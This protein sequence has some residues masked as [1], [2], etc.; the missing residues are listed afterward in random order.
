MRA[1]QVFG[2]RLLYGLPDSLQYRIKLA[3]RAVLK[4]FDWPSA[5]KELRIQEE[6]LLIGLTQPHA[7]PKRIALYN[8]QHSSP[9]EYGLAKALQLRGH[10]IHGILCDG[11]LPLCEMNLGP[12]IRPACG[13][14]FKFL[15]RNADAFGFTFNRLSNYLSSSDLGHA[16]TLVG[17]VADEDL[18]ALQV[19]GVPVGLF[20]HREIQRYYR[21]F[22]FK[23]EVD[24]SFRKWIVSAVLHTWLA[25]RWLDEVKPDI[26]GVCSGRTLP[27]ACV[28]EVA[29]QNDIH[30]VTW[31]GAA[32]RPDS[33]MF[34]HNE[35]ATEIPLDSLWLTYRDIPLSVTQLNELQTFMG[36]WSRSEI[37]PF[38]Y[39]PNPLKDPQAIAKQL[40]LRSNVPLVVAFTNTSWDIAVID[41]DH[42]FANMFEWI[43]ALVEF[44]LSHL[45]FDFVIRAHPA[46]KKVPTEM[47]SR[48]PVGEEIRK[49]FR[50][51]PNLKIV[52]GDDPISSY[53][54]SEMAQVNMFYASRLGL[55]IAL[56][57]KRPWIAGAVTY[58]NK[59]FTLDIASKQHLYSLLEQDL[60]NEVLDKPEIQLAER[61]AYLWFFRY[62]VRLPI[63][64]PANKQ[65]ELRSFA[66]LAPGNRVIDSLC[67]SFVT[68]K[69]FVASSL[70]TLAEAERASV[71]VARI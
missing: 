42:G 19:D 56:R 53:T 46:E 63:L 24:P 5:T 18:E 31:D 15:N 65:F 47:Q 4:D 61:F 27:T 57:G 48:T 64:H 9:V 3:K 26:V 10:D 62:E 23:P 67:E 30:V 38:P 25:Q 49:R 39:N 36:S 11:L 17:E 16:Q 52:E 28:F 7:T 44:A 59:G 43:F 66:D 58:R 45:Q 50:L 22:V 1:L 29:R 60:T 34:A 71:L 70:E 20:A 37:T 51:P 2:R 54:L 40:G 21:G 14:C 33:L 35:S 68:G 12:N 55:E 13:A 69:P 32:T 8:L 41:R 6:D